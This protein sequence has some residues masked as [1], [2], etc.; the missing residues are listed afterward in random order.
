MILKKLSLEDWN[1]V[2]KEAH[3]LC[4]GEERPMD[5]NTFDFALMVVT[6][7]DFPLAYSTN[8]ILDKNTVYMQHGGAFPFYHGNP[9]VLRGYH[10]MIEY[11]KENYSRIS[12]RVHNTNIRMLKLAMSAGLLINGIDC[13]E[14]DIFLNL[15]WSKAT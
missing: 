4:F 12:T 13:L 10:M 9:K 5:M 14:K 15:S 8:I 1:I 3:K 11:L 2:G 7:E 6:E